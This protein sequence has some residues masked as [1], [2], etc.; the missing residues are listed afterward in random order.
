MKTNVL[1]IGHVCHDKMDNGYKLGGT[2]SY[3]SLFAA[4][5]GGNTEIITSAGADFKYEQRFKDAG[6]KVFNF[7]CPSTTCFEN[8]QTPE[9]RQQF[10]HSRAENI[11][12]GVVMSFP[13]TQ[14][15]I[16][17]L[18]PIA[19]EVSPALSSLFT[20][21]TIG[22]SIQG[23]L[24][25]WHDNGK[26]YTA[27]Q[28]WAMLKGID[29]VFASDEDLS[30][31][32]KAVHYILAHT[33]NLVLTKGDKGAFIFTNNKKYYFPSYPTKVV[34][35]TGAGDVFAL[36]FLWSYHHDQS[37][38]KACIFAHSA[39]SILVE[40]H[41]I[42]HLPTIDEINQR[43]NEYRSLFHLETSP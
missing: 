43:L 38:S 9:G 16:V 20:G 29:V 31:D 24:R 23:W 1:C 30:H 19:N 14:P 11:S 15:Q 28:P 3:A 22:F 40:G 36:C 6:I 25:K 32:D 17:H 42:N 4:Q 12:E 26:V 7:P 33:K 21:S 5:L 13:F 39:A 10:L 41:N 2:V 34:D 8:I 27:N 18:G 35:T 37:L